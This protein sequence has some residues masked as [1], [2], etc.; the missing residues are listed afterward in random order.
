METKEEILKLLKLVK[1][2]GMGKLIKHLEEHGYFTSPASTKFHGNFEGGLAEHSL[3]VYKA[4]YFLD[5]W[6]KTKLPPDTKIICGLLHDVC[7]IGIY[8][9]K[10]KD[11]LPEGLEEDPWFYE[12]KDPFP[13]GH[14]EK[15]IIILQQYIKLTLEEMALI[16]WHMGAHDPS[17][18]VNQK[19]LAH[20]FPHYKL[21]YFADDIATH[22]MEET[23]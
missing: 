11:P 15:S 7:K 23:R 22:F 18:R 13:I 16:R 14:S 1:R 10:T 8:H 21:L 19:D 5:N 4:L 12:R 3:K 6:L 2:R 17:L 20:N 9:K